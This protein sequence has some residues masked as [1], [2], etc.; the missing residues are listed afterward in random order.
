VVV[1]E[2]VFV[3]RG[4]FET[5]IRCSIEVEQ[6]Q[7]NMFGVSRFLELPGKWPRR[8]S[9]FVQAVRATWRGHEG[10]MFR[11]FACLFASFCYFCLY[12]KKRMLKCA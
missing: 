11:D 8:L 4:D 3:F 1:R 2:A 10:Q 12:R 7:K 6:R 9:G 5:A